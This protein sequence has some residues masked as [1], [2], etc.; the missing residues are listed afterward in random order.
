MFEPIIKTD[1]SMLPKTI[2]TNLGE[3]EPFIADKCESAKALVVNPESIEDCEMAE[4]DATLL[5]KLQKRISTFRLTWTKQWQAPFEGVIAKCKDYERKL[6]DAS[7]DL[8]AKA[9][10][11]RDIVRDRKRTQLEGVWETLIKE[12]FADDYWVHFDT[13]FAMMTDEGTTGCWTN[14]GKKEKQITEEMVAELDRCAEAMRSLMAM[15]AGDTPAIQQVAKDALGR[16]FDM[17]EAIGAVNSYKAQQERIKAAEDAARERLQAEQGKT[18]PQQ[19]AKPSEA[20]AP[21]PAVLVQDAPV[22]AKLETYNLAVTGTRADLIALRKWGE[23]HGISFK[24]LD[25]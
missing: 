16:H 17:T 24:N 7:A 2:E 15:V 4:A 23:A 3:L 10:Q 9:K 6:G 25:R 11:G 13:F 1:I 12:R 8:K 21:S 20:P 22:T 19:V 5:T 14:R 18:T